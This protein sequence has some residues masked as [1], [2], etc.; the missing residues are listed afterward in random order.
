VDQYSGEFQLSEFL[1][2]GSERGL[3]GLADEEIEAW[4]EKRPGA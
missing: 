1:G 4:I 3:I 2:I